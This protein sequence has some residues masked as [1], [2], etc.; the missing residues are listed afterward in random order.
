ME[1]CT[2]CDE[3]G[4]AAYP[5]QRDFE[6]KKQIED[7]MSMLG[8]RYAAKSFLAYFQSYTSTFLGVKK[9]RESF[10]VALSFSDV[11]GIIIGTRPDCLSHAVLDLWK[12]YGSRCFVGVEF[13]VQSFFD[14]HLDFVKRGHTS[15]V[16]IHAIKRVKE[17]TG[18]D[19]GI[20]LI[21]GFPGETDQEIIKTAQIINELPIDNVKL[22]NLHVLKGTPLQKTFEQGEFTPIELDEYSRRVSLFLT[23]LSPEVAVHRLAAVSSRWD[24]LVA[25]QWTRHK[26]RSS[27]FI[28]DQL[29]ATQS[30]QGQN[31]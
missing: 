29:Q 11:K 21:F 1:V 30:F 28:I 12:E 10:E 6:I 22:H 9:L 15:Q 19:L 13:G 24:E 4:S 3:W 8:K 23:H 25:P 26:L 20:H 31:L 7:R 14:H 27:Q 17:M 5:D 18:V 16:S 2:F